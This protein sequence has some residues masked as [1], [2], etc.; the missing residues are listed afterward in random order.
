MSEVY[1]VPPRRDL[2]A[3]RAN[4]GAQGL[5]ALAEVPWKINTK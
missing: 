3:Q 4:A 1:K 2:A 5:N